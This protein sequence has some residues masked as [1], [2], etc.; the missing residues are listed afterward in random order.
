MIHD[1]SAP[2][3]LDKTFPPDI[4]EK[5]WRGNDLNIWQNQPGAHVFVNRLGESITVVNFAQPLP[6][7]KYGTKLARDI[8]KESTK[9]LQIHIELIQPRRSDPAWFNGNDALAP[10]IGFTSAQYD[11][12]ALLY[13]CASVR[14]GVWLIPAFHAAVDA[15]IKDAHDDPQNFELKKFC[16]SLSKFLS[17]LK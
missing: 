9:G 1:T 5:F 4:N 14:R 13:I 2:N 10:E 11:R 15:G 6:D 12:L 3:Y 7:K 16:Q 17:G 8:L